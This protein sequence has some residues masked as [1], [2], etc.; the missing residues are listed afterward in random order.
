MLP[1]KTSATDYRVRKVRAAIMTQKIIKVDELRELLGCSSATFSRELK[2]YTHSLIGLAYSQSHRVL[3]FEREV[4]DHISKITYN[5]SLRE[6][7]G[8]KH[9]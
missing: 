9:G 1:G 7:G 2:A 5:T 4:I 6:S 8:T 3:G